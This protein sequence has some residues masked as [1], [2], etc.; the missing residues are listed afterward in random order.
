MRVIFMGTPGFS[1]PALTS[2]ARS[3]DVVAVYRQPPRPA[4]RGHAVRLSPVQS[5]ARAMGLPVY[6]PAT[7]K[8]T[9]VQAEL[10]AMGVDVIVVVAYGLILP[11]PVLS[12]PRFGCVNIHASLL[13]RWR[14]AARLIG[15]SWPGIQRRES[16]LCRWMRALIP[17]LC[18]CHSP[19][20]LRRQQ[21][22]GICTIVS[23]HSAQHP[24]SGPY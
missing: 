9:D 6:H 11:Q 1:V 17:A 21:R 4:G 8:N 20:R 18:C 10:S 3:H 15:R 2:I 5:A 12:A 13:P 19:L 23:Q 14:G 16:R 24:S 22:R 7:L